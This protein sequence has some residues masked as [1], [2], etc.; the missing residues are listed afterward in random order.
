MGA[1]IQE[2]VSRPGWQ[3][4]QSLAVI[5]QGTSANAWARKFVHSFESN[6]ALA[7]RLVITY[8][9]GGSG[10][11]SQA[12]VSSPIL[13]SDLAQAMPASNNTSAANML[14]MGYY[15]DTHPSIHYN[16]L[17][18]T[19]NGAEPSGGSVHVANEMHASAAFEFQGNGVI[20]YL[21]HRAEGGQALACIDQQCRL[22]DTWIPSGIQ[23]TQPVALIGLGEGNHHL[24]LSNIS[25]AR[26]ELDAVRV[27]AETAVN[28]PMSTLVP[29]STAT[30]TPGIATPPEP[31]TEMPTATA[32]IEN[33][34]VP[35]LME[36][37]PASATPTDTPTETATTTDEPTLTETATETP[38]ATLPATVNDLPTPNL[39]ATPTLS[40]TELEGN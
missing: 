16:G 4:G 23:W 22:I 25:G 3:S 38:T 35:T 24:R 36:T 13:E 33:T 40:P 12:F 17:W 19:Y 27:L 31:A 14:L 7:P 11:Q 18:T 39:T 8:S 37:L 5:I 1:V 28:P 30:P 9:T 26:I 32:P 6:P 15:E 21:T 29:A 10:T 2:V 34:A 20:L